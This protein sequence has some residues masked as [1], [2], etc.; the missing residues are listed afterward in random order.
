MALARQRVEWQRAAVL[1]AAAINHN[2]WR[3]GNADP[4][5]LIPAEFR[6][7]R[8]PEPELTAEEKEQAAKLGWRMMDR[9]FGGKR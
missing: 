4:E 9:A 5:Q 3:A 6:P 1:T 8:E 7:P 2:A